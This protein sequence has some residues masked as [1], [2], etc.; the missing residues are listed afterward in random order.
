MKTSRLMLGTLLYPLL[1][2]FPSNQF[3][4]NIQAMDD[5][6]QHAK[7]SL[8]IN[9]LRAINTAELAY[10]GKHGSFAEWHILLTSEEFRDKGLKWAARQAPQLAD[11]HFSNGPEVLPGWNLRLNVTANAKS[12]DV[13]LEDT[14]DKDHGYAVQTDER[15]L[16]RECKTLE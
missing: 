16:I 6:S 14:N 5:S 1:F 11:A 13:L 8:A 10:R 12:Y 7:R 3:A 2:A 15:G 4:Q 9:F